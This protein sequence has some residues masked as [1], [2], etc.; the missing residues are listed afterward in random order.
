[1]I[2]IKCVGLDYNF[3]RYEI[4]IANFKIKESNKDKFI[5]PVLNNSAPLALMLLGNCQFLYVYKNDIKIN[6]YY[7]YS[8]YIS[9]DLKRKLKEIKFINPNNHNEFIKYSY[10]GSLKLSINS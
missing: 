3:S 8:F 10:N 7:C 9:D 2:S 4:E 6:N 1:M 5:S